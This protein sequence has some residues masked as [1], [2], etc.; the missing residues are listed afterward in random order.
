MG[1]TSC[2]TLRNNF[3]GQSDDNISLLIAAGSMPA[4][5]ADLEN[6]FELENNAPDEDRNAALNAIYDAN[7]VN[8]DDSILLI[9]E[10]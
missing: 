2:L 10:N 4:N 7:P 6:I 9:D 5:S 1:S 3:D 8:G